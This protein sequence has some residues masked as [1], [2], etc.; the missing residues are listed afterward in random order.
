MAMY[1]GKEFTE[2][3]IRMILLGSNNGLNVNSFAKTYYTPEKC[4]TL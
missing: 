2:Q 1:N 4:Q 3:Q